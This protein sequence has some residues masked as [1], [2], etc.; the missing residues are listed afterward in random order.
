MAPANRQRRKRAR[1]VAVAAAVVAAAGAA[2]TAAN[3]VGLTG[4]FDSNAADGADQVGLPPATAKIT[5]QTLLDTRTESGDLGLG[6]A[7]TVSARLGGTITALPEAGSTVGRGR[8]LYRVDNDPVVLLL[9]R[10]PAYRMLSPGLTG[11][12]VKQFEQNLHA[13]GYRGFTV[14]S[15]YTSSTASA[16][17]EWQGDLELTKTGTV[18][19]G[20]IFYAPAAVRVDTRKAALGDEVGRGKP[21]L[22]Y[23]GSA[24]V[25]TVELPY[26][27]K[28]LVRKGAKVGLTLPDGRTVP[29]KITGSTM[30]IKPAATAQDKAT[31]VFEVTVAADDPRVL[32]GLEEAALDVAFTAAER[33]NVLTVP[34]AALLAL[35]EGGYG[36]EV[37]EGN[38]TRIAAVQTGLYAGGRVEIT[39]DGVVEGAAVGMPT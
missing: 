20:R 28:R 33:R 34:V 24:Q 38:G 23:T 11:P 19:V 2:V 7:I 22:T 39:G 32:A 25:I 9:G 18:E 29:G 4:V 26:A 15:D 27:E 35:A 21:V 36:V 3:G 30:V 16:V 10:L 14:D 13:L 12:D 5:R 1:R 6:D 8:P 17:R 31:T 37:V